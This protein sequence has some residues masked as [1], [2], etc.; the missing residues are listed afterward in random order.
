MAVPPLLTRT[1]VPLPSS[2][3]TGERLEMA[4]D[5]PLRTTEAAKLSLEAELLADGDKLMSRHCPN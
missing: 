5:D 4:A 3:I 2:V 1:R